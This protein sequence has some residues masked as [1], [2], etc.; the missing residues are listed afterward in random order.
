MKSKIFLIII[1]SISIF[2]KCTNYGKNDLNTGISLKH[3]DTLLT[4]SESEKTNKESEKSDLIATT[5]ENIPIDLRNFI[6]NITKIEK[7][8]EYIDTTF[9]CYLIEEGP[10]IYPDLK[11]V[12]SSTD[13]IANSEFLLLINSSLFVN[14][15]Y[16]NQKNIDPCG[17]P[18]EGI[19]LN[20][21]EKNEQLLSSVY[22]SVQSNTDGELKK[23]IQEKLAN[24]SSAIVWK[25]IFNLP[26]K[27]GDLNSLIIN[28]AKVNDK[29]LIASV[30]TRNCGL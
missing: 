10:G 3:T 4:K 20:K 11:T 1:L 2:S 23:K 30:D 25:V 6:H 28:L 21:A 8:E 14:H 18:E 15:F 9:G 29:I 17:L 12:E 16:V 19:Y 13:L 5:S 27:T 22:E 7:I 26:T 24:V